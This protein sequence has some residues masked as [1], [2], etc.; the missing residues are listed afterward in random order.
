MKRVNNERLAEAGAAEPGVM[1]AVSTEV[2][3]PPPP[4]E[5]RW[6][7]LCSMEAALEAEV[8]ELR[9]T[10]ASPTSM[11]VDGG[12]SA[13]VEHERDENASPSRAVRSDAYWGSRGP[14]PVVRRADVAGVAP[15]REEG[16][17]EKRYDELQRFSPKPAVSRP[18]RRGGRDAGAPV[19]QATGDASPIVE[20]PKWGGKYDDDGLR[21]SRYDFAYIV[22]KSNKS[23]QRASPS[24]GGARTKELSTPPPRT[25]VLSPA[26]EMAKSWERNLRRGGGATPTRAPAVQRMSPRGWSRENKSN[27][28]HREGNANVVAEVEARVQ[29][30]LRQLEDRLL[31][32]VG[33]IRKPKKERTPSSKPRMKRKSDVSSDSDAGP[34]AAEAAVPAADAADWTVAVEFTEPLSATDRVAER[35]RLIGEGSSSGP[36]KDRPLRAV[37]NSIDEYLERRRKRREEEREAEREKER[38]ALETAAGMRSESIDGFEP[39]YSPVVARRA[40]AR[41]NVSKMRDLDG[42]DEM[43]E[44]EGGHQASSASPSSTFETSS[45]SSP[46]TTNIFDDDDF[47]QAA[48]AAT[49]VVHRRK[50]LAAVLE[51]WSFFVRWGRARAEAHRH[52]H[53]KWASIKV[54]RALTADARVSSRVSE[55][56]HRSARRRKICAALRGWLF[57]AKDAKVRAARE[58]RRRA[59]LG[60]WPSESGSDGDSDD[61]EPTEVLTE[62]DMEALRRE[63]WMP[64]HDELK[65]L[66]AEENKLIMEEREASSSEGGFSPENKAEFEKS[67]D[68]ALKAVD[69][70]VRGLIGL[71]QLATPEKPTPL[72]T[73]PRATPVVESHAPMTDPRRILKFDPLRVG[74]WLTNQTEPEVSSEEEEEEKEQEEQEGD[75][76][77]EEEQ[78]GE[79]AD[80]ITPLGS[81]PPSG[82]RPY[83]VLTNE[84][85]EAFV[86]TS[87]PDAGGSQHEYVSLT[88]WIEFASKSI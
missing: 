86:L 80:F 7:E 32:S 13:E 2:G 81:A 55:R 79:R 26:N 50:L 8:S 42:G 62:D 68:D 31:R 19:A 85:G 46:S 9:L 82:V 54:L 29:E 15:V 10:V 63:A 84:Q 43:T 41:V 35:S 87:S 4:G 17:Y 37:K 44:S 34:A 45:S 20:R 59:A 22:P 30:K 47:Y 71:W 38:R 1:E 49:E 66:D 12:R 83:R 56:F 48:S 53:L 25:S 58:R 65:V 78:E 75:V 69:I 36:L 24:R 33:K 23:H 16:D 72:G 88:D 74:D 18:A 67:Y 27:D 70:A 3:Y 52:R 76:E 6:E 57:I 61:S 11:T 14:R 64:L 51:E 21:V 40:S 77:Q 60:E 39:V 5:D 28:A 73:R